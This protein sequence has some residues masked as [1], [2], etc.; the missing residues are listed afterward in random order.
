MG[1][2]L[3]VRTNWIKWGAV[4]ALTSAF[5][6]HAQPATVAPEK[7]TPKT[8]T[9]DLRDVK[10]LDGPFKTA[11]ELNA[12]YLLSLDS[13]RLLSGVRQNAGLLPKAPRYGGWE[14]QGVAGQTLGHYMT[15]LAQ[16]YRA[17]GDERFRERLAY[18]VKELA[19]CQAKDPTGY[20]AAIPDGK[21]VF[22][23]MKKRGGKMLGWVP[24]Y[25]MHKLL[26][27]LRDAWL[28]TGNEQARAVLIRLAEWVDFVTKDLT[29]QEKEVMLSM[30]H[31]GMN[32]TL[33]DVYAIT[34]DSK[35]LTT[36]RR[37]CHR[38]VMDSLA[39]GEDRLNGL[40]ANTQI[41]KMTGAARL[42]ELTGENYFRFV[43]RNFWEF[44]V[45]N[46]SYAIGGNSDSEHFFPPVEHHRH[47]TSAT[48]ETCNTYNM[49]KLTEHLFAWEPDARRM[50]YY[51]RA[52]YNQILASQDP[53]TG[54]FTYFVPMKPGHFKLYSDPTNAFW[55]CV[56][57]GMENHTKYGQAIYA[58]SADALWVNLFMASEVTWK[59]KGLTL[60]QETKFPES[61][62]TRLTFQCERP[63]K[64]TLK[65]RW[66]AW[67]RSFV[68]TINGQ[69][70]NFA[71][72]EPHS[73]LPLDREWRDGDVVEY[74][75]PMSLRTEPLPHTTNIQAV[76]YGPIVLAAELGSAGM[77]SLKLYQDNHNQDFY[78]NLPAPVTPVLVAE[79]REV[80]SRIQP[81]TGKPLTFQTRGLVQPRDVT[82]IPFY[83]M[84]HQRYSVYFETFTPDEW[85]RRQAELRAEEARRKAIEARVV[86]DVRPG[87]QQSEVDHAFKAETSFSGGDSPKWRDARNGG[88]F[89]YQLRVPSGQPAELR[90]TYWGSDAG[91]RQFDILVDGQKI[92]TE[93]LDGRRPNEHFDQS[94]PISAAI[95]QGKSHVTIRFQAHPGNFAGGVFG[96]RLLKP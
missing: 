43:A 28:F 3:S 31:G 60:R 52:L 16:Q 66:P 48:A 87:E 89:E 30:E 41:P 85:T 65:L 36:A 92:A 95:T 54:M 67:T 78:R 83:R 23:G 9:F 44:V 71:G 50:D 64:V 12:K 94:Y 61:D 24:W 10:L 72:V 88:W 53:R 47:L 33:A 76:L 91:N 13:D 6:S 37:F 35:H 51:E 75:L 73:Y 22:E 96:L 32:E 82:L 11:M 49:L 5:L 38:F 1:T 46:R 77:A 55:C 17:T 57:T 40:H 70:L 79:N 34:G 56:G 18:I 7:V 80:L 68:V 15:A 20:V 2:I 29:E 58:H 93:K 62:T 14:S 25:T 45:T 84:H 86:D 4:A 27:G 39:R 19:E 8:V 81:A 42:H 21:A 69:T 63:V 26:Q 74:T 59:D 90:V